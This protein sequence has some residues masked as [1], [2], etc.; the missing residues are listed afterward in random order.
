MFNRNYYKLATLSRDNKPHAHVA[1][2]SPL[3]PSHDFLFTSLFTFVPGFSPVSSI[4]VLLFISCRA[5]TCA[6]HCVS[7][8]LTAAQCCQPHHKK[9]SKWSAVN[10]FVRELAARRCRKVSNLW[11]IPN[12]S[13]KTTKKNMPSNR[14]HRVFLYSFAICLF[15]TF[16]TIAAKVFPIANLPTSEF[17]PCPWKFLVLD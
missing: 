7:P 4:V 8:V 11:P 3:C 10:V 6:F 2:R 14:L 16:V 13:R 9:Y 5:R 15:V 17:P 12:K 1:Y